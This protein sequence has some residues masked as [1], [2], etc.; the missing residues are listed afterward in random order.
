[1]SV[2]LQEAL[3]GPQQVWAQAAGAWGALCAHCTEVGG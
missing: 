1:M 2:P 3:P